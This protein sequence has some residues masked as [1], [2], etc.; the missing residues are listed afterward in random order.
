MGRALGIYPGKDGNI[1]V[2]LAGSPGRPRLLP[3]PA[4]GPGGRPPR[5]KVV[6]ALPPGAALVRR[7]VLPFTRKDRLAKALRFQA[8]RFLPGVSAED[9]L[10]GHL[11]IRSSRE[12]T[13]LLLAV[14]RKKDVE[15]FLQGIGGQAGRPALVIPAWGAVL[16][17]LSSTGSLPAR[18]LWVVLSFTGETILLF[19]LEEGAPLHVRRIPPGEGGP[20]QAARL[21]REIG[22]TLASA[23][24]DAPL[25]GILALRPLPPALDP[26]ELERE[27]GLTLGTLDPL[28]SFGGGG[29][30]GAAPAFGAALAGLGAS[31]GGP[32][33]R[34]REP[35]ER[36]LYERVRGPLLLGAF[37]LVL[38]L[39]FSLLA[40]MN[41]RGRA[42]AYQGDLSRRA[43]TLFHRFV[44]GGRPRFSS[45]FDQTLENLARRRKAR[46]D[47]GGSWESFLDFLSLLTR[48]LPVDPR[49]VI[50]SVD[51]KG[52]KATL[53]G[54]ADDVTVLDALAHQL[55]QSGDFLVRTPFRMRGGNKGGRRKPLAFTIE[56]T[57][58]RGR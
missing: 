29:D 42:E 5:A 32:V 37:L 55:E 44:K 38:Y 48:S 25:E 19:L 45:T 9:L 40:A 35:E 49:R 16:A 31:G 18:G 15:G 27:T 52:G 1:L 33:L 56:L 43:R 53:R 51:F 50:L 34:E 17:L 47:G 2:L 13:D 58:R 57:P 3:P 54:E 4:G 41:A 6:L 10:L 26:E 46:G 30:E 7:I 14:A 22:F 28:S 23:G 20:S 36:G 8:E 21:A 12:G 24:V 11:V 39:A